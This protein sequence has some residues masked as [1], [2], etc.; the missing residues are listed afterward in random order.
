MTICLLTVKTEA[1]TS[2]YVYDETAKTL[3]NIGLLLN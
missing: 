1:W 2:V 3:D